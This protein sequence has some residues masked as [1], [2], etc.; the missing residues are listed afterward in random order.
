[1]RYG[2]LLIGLC[3]CFSCDYFKQESQETP[4]ARVND[5]YLYESDIRALVPVDA[6]PEDSTMLVN[7]YINRWATQQ[8][9]IDQ[10]K[11]N[12]PEDDQETYDKLVDEY[13]TDLYTEAY[14]NAIVAKQLDSA[15][16]EGEYLR[17]YEENKETFTLNEPLVKVRYVQVGAGFNRLNET[18]TWLSRFNEEDQQRLD[19]LSIQFKSYNLN[20]STWVKFKSL[21]TAI[22]PLATYPSNDLKNSNLRQLQDSLG[23]Y[24]VKITEVL[25]PTDTAPIEF[26]RPTIEQIILNKRKLELIRKLEKDITKDAINNKKYETYTL[27]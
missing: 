22:P 1:M 19:E 6:T 18:G 21:R 13:K 11:I 5:T 17:F 23:V 12:L 10:A 27:N 25:M 16:S 4:V 20:D 7:T 9:L 3:V 26:V 15:I 14:K 2:I 8:L 24:L